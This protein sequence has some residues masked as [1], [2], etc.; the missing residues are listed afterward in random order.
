MVHRLLRLLKTLNL[1]TT[2]R[3]PGPAPGTPSHGKAGRKPQPAQ[4]L[5]D[6]VLLARW[7]LFPHAHRPATKAMAAALG[8]STPTWH[9]RVAGA[10]RLSAAQLARANALLDAA[11]PWI[12]QPPPDTLPTR[13]DLA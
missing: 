6:A 1:M 13:E 4:T 12:Q 2:K 7:Q 5:A 10:G 9:R 11:A 3:K 8:I